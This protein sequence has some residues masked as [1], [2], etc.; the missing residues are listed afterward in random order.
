MLEDCEEKIYRSVSL[1]EPKIYVGVSRNKNFK[2][3][4]DFWIFQAKYSGEILWRFLQSIDQSGAPNR[5]NHILSPN[6]N[7]EF[8][9]Y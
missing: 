8:S 2:N 6:R 5:R 4:D 3:E 9:K 1:R 7:R